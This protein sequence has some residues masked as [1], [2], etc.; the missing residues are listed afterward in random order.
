M[1]VLVQKFAD[2]KTV[3]GEEELEKKEDSW[4]DSWVESWSS[5]IE[6]SGTAKRRGFTRIDTHI[7]DSSREESEEE[8]T[9][10]V[11]SDALLSQATGERPTPSLGFNGAFTGIP[12][13]QTLKGSFSAVSKPV[14]AIQKSFCSICGAL[15]YHC[16]AVFI[17]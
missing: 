17:F 6:P 14:F 7:S 13:T 4:M 1:R 8:A 3:T 12:V 9:A 10:G 16:A 15:D 11:E 5:W 2:E